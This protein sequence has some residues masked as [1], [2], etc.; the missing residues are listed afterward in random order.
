MTN[1]RSGRVAAYLAFILGVV[2]VTLNAIPMNSLYEIQAF[3]TVRGTDKYYYKMGECAR[4]STSITPYYQH[5]RSA[6]DECGKKVKAGDI[7][8]KWNMFGLF[9][10]RAGVPTGKRFSDFENLERSRLYVSSLYNGILPDGSTI[11]GDYAGTVDSPIIDYT[12][13]T[14]HDPNSHDFGYYSQ[15]PIKHERYGLRAELTTLFP[16]GLGFN[17]RAGATYYRRMPIFTLLESF[18]GN[19]GLTTTNPDGSEILAPL[20]KSI[21]D[22]TARL[23][24][25]ELMRDKKRNAIGDELE[26][27]FKH[28]CESHAEDVHLNLFWQY[29]FECRG[30]D[31][32]LNCIIAPYIAC[33]L[34]LPAGIEKDEIKAFS[35]PTGN[36]GTAGLTIEGQINMAFPEMV[37]FG[38]GG[39]LLISIERDLISMPVPTHPCQSGIYPWK[40][41]VRTRPGV[42]WY[43]NA[44]MK[45]E[46]IRYLHFYADYVFTEHLK[47][48]MVL[49][50]ESVVRATAF[51]EGLARLERN[52]CWRN[53]QVHVGAEYEICPALTL[54]MGLQAHIHGMRT[55]HLTNV[56]GTI[57]F[58]F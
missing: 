34:W 43:V 18:R 9:Y 25:D 6:R 42:T 23:L 26:Q 7:F 2:N 17:I 1:I 54:G 14:I 39:G 24:Y 16:C 3:Y 27:D 19:A 58:T 46:F 12:D 38:L 55:Y 51:K 47:D 13:E 32:D 44:S 22:K 30:E 21:P 49:C 48:D 10:G 52:S 8:G 57:R 41:G 53:Q 11:I 40:T 15:I 56:M 5:T 37:Q 20:P 36:N 4:I 29:G 31:G 33:G 28:V 35:I 50:E 45:A